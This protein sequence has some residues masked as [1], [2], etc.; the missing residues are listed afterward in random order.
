[1]YPILTVRIVQVAV[2]VIYCFFAAG[3]VFGYAAIKPVLKKEGAYR[4]YCAAEGSIVGENT[5]IEIHLNLMFTV[6]AVAT[7][8]AALPIGAILDRYGP[9]VCGLLGSFFL[10]V[11]ALLMSF[12]KQV[13][14]D[15]LLF[16]C[17]QNLS[18]PRVH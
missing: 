2:A 9:R 13:P 10:A 8:V 12:E 11:G 14:F 15:G 6:A 5:C 16:G 7:N 4:D 1:M 3:I 17:K 18:A